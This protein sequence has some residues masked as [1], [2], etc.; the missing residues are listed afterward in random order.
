MCGEKKEE[1]DLDDER[2]VR[3]LFSSIKS[4]ASADLQERMRQ[5]GGPML[6]L[7]NGQP[8]GNSNSNQ[9]ND[10][11]LSDLACWP[12]TTSTTVPSLQLY[13]PKVDT[14]GKKGVGMHSVFIACVRHVLFLFKN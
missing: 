8:L 4:Q 10:K 1:M 14:V 5:A 11:K 12:A 13:V 7:Y 6:L 2:P 9:P 3:Q